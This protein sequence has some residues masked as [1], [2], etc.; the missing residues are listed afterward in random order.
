MESIEPFDIRDAVDFHTAY[1]AG[2]LADKYDVDAQASIE[3]ANQRIRQ[4]TEDAFASTV[5][6]YSSVIPVSNKIRLQNGRARYALY[7]VWVLNTVWNGQKFTFGV[8]GQTGKVA[9]DLPMDQGAFWTWLLGVAGAAAA[10]A[11]GISYLLHVL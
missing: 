1:L 3:R 9:G 5:L 8:N 4:S 6:G 7:P 2:Y 10:V 11:Y